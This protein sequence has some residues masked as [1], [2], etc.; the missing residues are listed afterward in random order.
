LLLLVVV[1]LL[2]VAVCF[3]GGGGSS[4]LVGVVG[5]D[6]PCFVVA[7]AVLLL[8]VV[9]SSP[10]PTRVLTNKALSSETTKTNHFVQELAEPL[11]VNPIGGAVEGWKLRSDCHHIFAAA[12]KAIVFVDQDPGADARPDL[13]RMT[14]GAVGETVLHQVLLLKP[15]S[16]APQ[17]NDIIAR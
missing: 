16:D 3:G 2:L 12:V 8:L 6:R 14:R 4:C 10:A 5:V 7:V 15:S 11:H 1:V 17:Y 9:V 13:R